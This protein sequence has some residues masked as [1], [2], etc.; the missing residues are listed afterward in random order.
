MHA[1]VSPGHLW[2][3][4]STQN[5]KIMNPQLNFTSVACYHTTG[6]LC[7]ASNTTTIMTDSE[8]LVVDLN[9]LNKKQLAK[10]FKATVKDIKAKDPAKK[11][12]ALDKFKN[13]RYLLEGGCF[14][15][16]LQSLV[17]K[18]VSNPCFLC[19]DNAFWLE[20]FRIHSWCF[21]NTSQFLTVSA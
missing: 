7:W 14:I 12:D 6:S 17:P 19:C 9:S 21:V 15:P 10:E 13:P 2:P 20:N 16:F 5:S 8:C 4:H 1:W 18:P 3:L 11:R